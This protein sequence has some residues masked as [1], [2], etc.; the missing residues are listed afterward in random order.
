MSTCTTLKFCLDLYHCN[1]PLAVSLLLRLMY[2]LES[3]V[4]LVQWARFSIESL[5]RSA[6]FPRTLAYIPLMIKYSSCK[7]IYGC[8]AELLTI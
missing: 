6:A 7:F 3:Y 2:K 5:K 4:G 8:Y 1:K